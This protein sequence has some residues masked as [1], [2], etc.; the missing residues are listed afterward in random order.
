[1]S[2][3]VMAAAVA[4]AAGLAVFLTGNVGIMTT[5]PTSPSPR[6][7]MFRLINRVRAFR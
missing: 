5:P 2:I 4:A 7:T 1:M 3:R 6:T